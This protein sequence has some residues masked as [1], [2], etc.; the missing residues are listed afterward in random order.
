MSS[1]LVKHVGKRLRHYGESKSYSTRTRN[2]PK[3][4]R[5]SK[6]E[7]RLVFATFNVSQ[8]DKQIL[9][10]QNYGDSDVSMW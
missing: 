8:M 6:R 10:G 2:V 7:R 5:R 4:L 3:P 1:G 9:S